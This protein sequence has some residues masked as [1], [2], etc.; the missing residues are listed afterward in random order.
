MVTYIF[1]DLINT[2]TQQSTG[3]NPVAFGGDQSCRLLGLHAYSMRDSDFG[4]KNEH[5]KNKWPSQ[6]E[7]QKL[8]LCSDDASEAS[9][10]R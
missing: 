6:R 9:R 8:T 2:L 5:V 4:M 1:L 10:C 7:V 3:G